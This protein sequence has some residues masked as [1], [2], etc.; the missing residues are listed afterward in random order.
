M[1]FLVISENLV[2]LHFCNRISWSIVSNDFCRSI[3]ISVN[4]PLSN[5]FKSLKAKIHLLNNYLQNPINSYLSSS[6]RKVFVWSWITL[7]IIFEVDESNENGLQ[8]EGSVFWPFLKIGFSFA[9]LQGFEKTPWDSLAPSFKNLP[10]S[11]ST[12]AA[13]KLSIFV[14]IFKTFSSE[15]LRKQKS[16]EIE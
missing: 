16:S 3:I 6:D 5:P 1:N 14:I 2:T 13:L 11:L 7:S 12:P 10:K 8:L 4:K 9:T 15:V